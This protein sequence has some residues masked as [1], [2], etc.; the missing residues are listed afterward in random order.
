MG[1]FANVFGFSDEARRMADE[2]NL[3]VAALGH[4]ASRKWVAIRLSDGGSDGV[5]YDTRRDA[6][7]HQVHEKQCCYVRLPPFGQT[8]NYREAESYLTFHR[9]IY[10]AG[11]RLQDPDDPQPIKP[12]VNVAAPG[13]GSTLALPWRGIWR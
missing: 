6:I 3:H 12:L 5:L 13:R 4:A 7:V 1:S 10:D 9:S 11:Y 8:M 2:V